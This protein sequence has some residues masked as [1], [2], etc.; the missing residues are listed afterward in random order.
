MNKKNVLEKSNRYANTKFAFRFF[1]S[2]PAVPAGKNIC[3]SPAS[4]SLCFG[5]VYEAGV[6]LTIPEYAEIQTI[7]GYPRTEADF[8]TEMRALTSLKDA[9]IAN[10]GFVAQDIQLTDF[11]NTQLLS[12]FSIEFGR[13]NLKKDPIAS[14][15]EINAWV[16][17]AT[18]GRIKEGKWKN[19]LDLHIHPDYNRFYVNSNHPIETQ[20]MFVLEMMRSSHLNSLK[21]TIVELP[22]IGE[23]T[24]IAVLPDSY[25]HCGSP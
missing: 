22:Y 16:E 14:T 6:G 20:M 23:A 9:V 4:I 3:F 12:V 10:S 25:V 15:K 24:F 5:M 19:P 13:L 21:A 1:I 18:N 7:F 8:N 17:K 2:L 11:Y